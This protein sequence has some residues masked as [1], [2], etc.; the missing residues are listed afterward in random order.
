MLNEFPELQVHLKNA[1]VLDEPVAE[2]QFFQKALGGANGKILLIGDAVGFFDHITGEGIGIA[3]RQVL[4]LEKYVEPVFKE[5]SGNLVKAMFDY[6][7]ASAQIYRRYQIMT[8]LVLLLR[9]WPKLTD[10]VIQVLY[11]FPAL[12]Q[13]L[14]SV[15]MR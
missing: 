6:S 8:S 5:N 12:F 14:L 7:R 1:D 4:Q 13:K 2:A 10:G 9:L 11:S 3:A 15:N